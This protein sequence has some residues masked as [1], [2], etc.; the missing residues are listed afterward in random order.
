M[1]DPRAVQ[2]TV[3]NDIYRTFKQEI[4]DEL[5]KAGRKVKIMELLD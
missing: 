3:L 5:T 1:R 2:V 4:L